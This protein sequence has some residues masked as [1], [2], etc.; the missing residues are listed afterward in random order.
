[1]A[2]IPLSHLVEH[3]V[4]IAWEF[5]ERSGDLGDEALASLFLSNKIGERSRLLLSN[6]A[7]DAY[8]RQFGVCEAEDTRP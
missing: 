5:L 8:R 6:R 4:Q 3:S 2:D 7:I 1:M